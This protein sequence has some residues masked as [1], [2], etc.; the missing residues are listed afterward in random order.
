[1]ATEQEIPKSVD[2]PATP[3]GADSAS[4][5]ELAKLRLKAGERDQY[6]D[7]LQ[8]SRA[9]FENYQKRAQ[10]DREQE[11]RYMFGPLVFDFL[12]VLDNLER[13]LAAAQQAGETGALVQGV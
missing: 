1:M 5:E 3:N 13:A 2:T 4:G 6:L 12:P 9:E 11:R 10:K 8:R 7:M